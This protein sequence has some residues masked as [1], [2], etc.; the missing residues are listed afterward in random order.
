MAKIKDLE[1]WR[2]EID[3][4]EKFRDE[5]LGVFTDKERSKAGENID[6]YERGYCDRI[7]SSE[8]ILTTI[9]IVDALTS[10]I[11][12]SL[13]FK[14]PRT[15]TIP[16]NPESEDTAP[17]AGKMID[18]FKKRI[19]VEDT[20]KLVVFDSYLIGCGFYKIGYVT[21]F[22]KNIED[23]DLKKEQERNLLDKAL[24]RI[25]LKKPADKP[26]IRPEDDARIVAESP[27]ID[28]ISPF[29]FGIDPRARDLDNAMYWFHKVRKSVKSLKENKKYRNTENLKGYQP[30]ITTL[31]NTDV[32]ESTLDEFK[33]V[34]LYEIHYR[35]DNKFYLLYLS[36][37]ASGEWKEHYHEESIY[38]MGEWQADMLAFK[39]HGHSLYPRSD[40]TKVKGLQDQITSTIDAIL[41]Q[42]SK[43]VPKIAIKEG[44]LTSEG[45]RALK[46]GG[47]GAIVKVTDD[48]DKVIKELSFTQLKADLAALIDQ[49]ISL[50]TIQ[51]GLTRAQLTGISDSGS[52]TEATIE[53]G[54]QT[55]RLS[56]MSAKVQSFCNRQSRKIWKVIKQFVSLEEL[57]L[58]NGAKGV[59][60]N[61]IPKYNWLT[62][63]TKQAE[64]MQTGDY[65][66]DIEV[67]STEKINLAVIRKSFENM[68]NI[69][70]RT[71]VIALM[72]A[73]GDDVKLSEML[74]RYIELFPEMGLDVNKIVQKR[75]SETGGSVIPL[76]GT[77]G[78]HTEGS[79]LNKMRS[80]MSQSAPGMGSQ[81]QG[82]AQI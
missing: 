65:D 33:T 60:E 26:V 59:D 47:T 48:I 37:D 71:E 41:D 17:L 44:G 16:N 32:E 34:Y 8:D 27:F 46:E 79:N 23:P 6:Y 81:L 38:E 30:D 14:N 13:H 24:E 67:G 3:L 49:L 56:D 57:Q 20:N 58:I 66:F 68:F 80:Q 72:Q 75:P 62:I 21:R 50:I 51:T 55:I 39:K 78:G 18:H 45:E 73:Q 40:I 77:Q 19:G 5:E 82:A 2:I 28:Y 10:I 1:R 7:V 61:G 52:A 4:A 35:N 53:Q 43:F 36:D 63:S 74:K 76:T 12:P 29:H 9:N 54:G 42:V 22:G 11:V 70:A 31:N 25:G 64:K 69:L 15:I